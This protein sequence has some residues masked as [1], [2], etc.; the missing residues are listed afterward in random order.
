MGTSRFCLTPQRTRRL[1]KKRWATRFCG[2]GQKFGK[3]A[4]PAR[5][6]LRIARNSLSLTAPSLLSRG[7]QRCFGGI[8]KADESPGHPAFQILC[9]QLLWPASRCLRIARETFCL[10]GPSFLSRATLV[11]GENGKPERVR[12]PPIC[13]STR[14]ALPSRPNLEKRLVGQYPFAI[15]TDLRVRNEAGDFLG[16]RDYI[17]GLHIP[18]INPSRR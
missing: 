18:Y 6:C 11:H 4:P 16:R 13:C 2:E 10:T 14:E 5:R 8:E 9:L 17:A 1:R 3:G 12:H 7:T 15:C